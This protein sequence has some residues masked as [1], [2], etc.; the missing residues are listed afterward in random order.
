MTE[1]RASRDRRLQALGWRTIRI[2]WRQLQQESADL[3]RDLRSLLAL[4]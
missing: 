1:K 3:E 4:R 2:T